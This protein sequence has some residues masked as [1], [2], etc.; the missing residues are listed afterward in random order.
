MTALPVLRRDDPHGVHQALAALHALQD[1]SIITV[2]CGQTAN[3]VAV[4]SNWE[5]CLMIGRG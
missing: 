2:H 1:R 3:K 4:E 5:T